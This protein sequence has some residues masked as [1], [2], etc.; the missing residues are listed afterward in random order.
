MSKKRNVEYACGCPQGVHRANLPLIVIAYRCDDCF[1]HNKPMKPQS[2]PLEAF[3]NMR[4]S[5]GHKI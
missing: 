1:R 5:Y 2:D 3:I 4:L